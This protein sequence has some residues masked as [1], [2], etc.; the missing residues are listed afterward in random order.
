MATAIVE[1]RVCKKCG[2]S[3]RKSNGA[4]RN[5]AKVAQDLWRSK[6]QEKIKAHTSDYYKKNK[7]ALNAKNKVW[8]RENSKRMSEYYKEYYNINKN[9]ILARKA[10]IRSESG[11]NDN[12]R[13]RLAEWA[14]NN[15]ESIRSRSRKRRELIYSAGGRLSKG[16]ANTLFT[17]QR[18]L[19]PCCM[20][21]L[22]DK[23]HLDHIMPV[24]RGGSNTDDNMQLLRAQCNLQKKAKHPVDFMRERGFLL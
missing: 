21:P 2:T 24:S 6:S 5:C 3:N 22:G 10:S 8:Y 1:V 12:V 20:K 16:L 23:Y 13:A 14:K 18:G 15:G 7:D 4:C 9:K 17:L 19:C 11:S